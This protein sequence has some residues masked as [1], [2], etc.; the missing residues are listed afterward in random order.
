[1]S[2]S[3]VDWPEVPEGKV[4]LAEYGSGV[5]MAPRTLLAQVEYDGRTYG[6][7]EVGRG[8]EIAGS[9]LRFTERKYVVGF[10]DQ[11]FHGRSF[12][13]ESAARAWLVEITS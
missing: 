2:A 5:P 7:T 4:R 9:C 13:E 1:M 8:F 3:V 11:A 12:R 6:L 10:W